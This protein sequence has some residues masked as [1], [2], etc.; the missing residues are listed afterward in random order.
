MNKHFHLECLKCEEKSIRIPFSNISFLS[1][2]FDKSCLSEDLRIVY[3]YKPRVKNNTKD[4]EELRA[5][6]LKNN[7]SRIRK[8]LKDFVNMPD[9]TY[10]SDVDN[11]IEETIKLRGKIIEDLGSYK[12]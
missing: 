9:W 2:H 10:G 6:E 1:K 8:I 4:Y 5:L 12:N 7:L 3:E 11:I